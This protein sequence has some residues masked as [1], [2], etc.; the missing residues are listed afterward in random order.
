MV[1]KST[2]PEIAKIINLLTFTLYLCITQ[3]HVT[4]VQRAADHCARALT[5]AHSVCGGRWPDGSS[6]PRQ[7]PAQIRPVSFQIR[8]GLSSF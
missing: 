7:D 1:M 6:P 5:L 3:K 8:L 2:H 4:P